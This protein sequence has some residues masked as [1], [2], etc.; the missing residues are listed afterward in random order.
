MLNLSEY[1]INHKN[2]KVS[3]KAAARNK[4]VTELIKAVIPKNSNYVKYKVIG[5]M[6][7]NSHDQQVRKR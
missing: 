1:V 7:R 2:Q 6:Y 4:F 3:I 5:C